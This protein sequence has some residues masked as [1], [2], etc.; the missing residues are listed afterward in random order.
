MELTKRQINWLNKR[1]EGTWSLNPQTGLVDVKGSFN[2]L[3]TPESIDKGIG[4]VCLDRM[5]S[6]S[7]KILKDLNLWKLKNFKGVRF[8]VITGDFDC[9]WNSLTT[10]E[11]AP[12]K[13]GG[14]FWCSGN[15][16]T[17][18]EGAPQK[19]EGSFYCNSNSLTTLEGA[20]QKVGGNFYCYDN[21]LTTLEGAPQE[22]G[23]SFHCGDNP[24]PEDVLE[25]IWSIMKDKKVPYLIALGIYKK[26]VKEAIDSRLTEGISEKA[27]K[28]ASLLGRVLS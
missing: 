26:E 7:V 25:A 10:L 18:L 15:S 27:L 16:L 2:C 14:Y 4:P 23:G 22:V 8:G 1:T 3:T 24:V 9:R 11:G 28:G 12:Q 19:V 6:G 5:L 21:S 20:P 13:V 17:S